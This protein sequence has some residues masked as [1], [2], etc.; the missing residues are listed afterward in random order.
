MPFDHFLFLRTTLASKEDVPK[1]ATVAG[2][3]LILNLLNRSRSCYLHTAGGG[4]WWESKLAHG[5]L[6]AIIWRSQEMLTPCDS[7]VYSS[8]KKLEN[9]MA[10]LTP[11]SYLR[12]RRFTF[13]QFC[14]GDFFFLEGWHMGGTRRETPVWPE[15]LD[16]GPDGRGDGAEAD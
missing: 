8:E 10:S 7:Q 5:L 15:E 2:T 13:L 6:K 11:R 1:E 4:G 3:V 14:G 9:L 12:R 16:F